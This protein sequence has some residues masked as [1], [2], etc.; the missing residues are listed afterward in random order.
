MFNNK[1]ITNYTRKVLEKRINTI[2]SFRVPIYFYLKKNNSKQHKIAK[3]KL[4]NLKKEI[5]IL[6]NDMKRTY[7]YNLA[8]YK[9][10]EKL[11][12]AIIENPN[13]YSCI[14]NFDEFNF[15][16][17]NEYRDMIF[18][19]IALGHND[20][21][22]IENSTK[23]Q[24][25]YNMK[26]NKNVTRKGK[27]GYYQLTIKKEG[28]NYAKLYKIPFSTRYIA[29]KMNN[30]FSFFD[31]ENKYI[32]FLKYMNITKKVLSNYQ[33]LLEKF[34]N[35]HNPYQVVCSIYHPI[36]CAE[37]ERALMHYYYFLRYI[38]K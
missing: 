10:E 26:Y 14:T 20:T 32:Y 17:K 33:K 16:T 22:F 34:S 30:R 15:Y 5:D 35:K 1:N 38:L 29:N 13:N 2:D 11:A 12:T 3:K 36:Y 9:A 6:L 19:K 25:Q 24:T 37:V 8:L 23:K 31:S 7:L 4:E 28:N 18:Y 27:E 21:K